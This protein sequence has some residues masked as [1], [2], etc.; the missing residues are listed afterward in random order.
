MILNIIVLIFEVL[1]YSLFMKFARNEGKFHRY[2]IL[3]SLITIVMLFVGTSNLYSY[4]IFVIL[5]LLGIK[6]LIKE[7]A[8]LY[9]MLIIFIML[10]IKLLIETPLY[11]M[12]NGMLS[13]YLIG[14]ITGILKVSMV[15]IFKN[16]IN[17]FYLKFSNL[18]YKNNFYIRYIFSILM[19]I[20]CILSCLFIIFYYM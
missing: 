8:G 2:L 13:I 6:Y 5:S 12:L 14:I 4:L 7:K 3:F 15:L 20:Y 17:K 19:L 18:W 16:K 9:D 11:F 1:Y 10:L